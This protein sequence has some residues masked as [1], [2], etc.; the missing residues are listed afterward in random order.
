MSPDFKMP[1]S[2]TANLPEIDFG[3]GM[4]PVTKQRVSN[5][6]GAFNDEYRRQVDAQR[7]QRT[8]QQ[9]AE[10]QADLRADQARRAKE[11]RA[12]D[13]RAER[14][15]QERRSG[16]EL[17]DRERPVEKADNRRASAQAGSADERDT[18]TD[19]PSTGDRKNHQVVSENDPQP[20]SEGDAVAQQS[21]NVPVHN[22]DEAPGGVKEG[23][24]ASGLE[25]VKGDLSESLEIA[26]VAGAV[27]DDELTPYVAQQL[28][29]SD[30]PDQSEVADDT[31]TLDGV[32]PESGLAQWMGQT[33]GAEG[34][35]TDQAGGN[36]QGV[37]DSI[38]RPVPGATQGKDESIHVKINNTASQ[39]GLPMETPDEQ[40][41]T[42]GQNA[43]NSRLTDKL[44]QQAGALSM[45]PLAQ[46][47]NVEKLRRD[48]GAQ[49]FANHGVQKSTLDSTVS[50]SSSG[51]SLSELKQ[52]M[53][54]RKALLEAGQQGAKSNA[55]ESMVS[56]ADKLLAGDKKLAGGMEAL[57]QLRIPGADL[58]PA[59]ADDT[60]SGPKAVPFARALDSASTV[61]TDESKPFSTTISTPMNKPGF[62]PEFNQ[63]IMMMIGQKIQTAEIKL[64]PEELGTIDV[65]VKFNQEQQASIVFASQQS[66]TREALEQGAQRLR[67][68][69][70]ENGVDLESVDIQEQ[71]ANGRH[72]GEEGESEAL[73]DEKSASSEIASDDDESVEG[74]AIETDSL[75]DFY[76]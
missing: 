34:K 2:A 33:L 40:L 56:Q 74:V 47:V 73:A 14:R 35:L 26:L 49:E 5:D 38:V 6:S 10:R 9:D 50:D 66:A 4:E 31:A 17:P 29:Q 52:L 75:V 71:L 32:T 72:Q 13:Q 65:T 44:P 55:D 37:Q 3:A 76:A 64:T 36:S 57:R 48:G 67:D 59:K 12:A 42:D 23:T 70:E 21:D 61:K 62:V 69:L 43:T 51:F 68:M 53:Q 63:R 7:S 46:A 22:T 1:T 18:P 58:N 39:A 24:K 45:S 28:A 8:Q 19:R 25:E 15:E 60:A 30:L 11:D 16:N 27:T 41:D 20:A 54:E